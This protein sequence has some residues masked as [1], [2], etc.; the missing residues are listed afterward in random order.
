MKLCPGSC[1]YTQS[2]D[3]VCLW[4]FESGLGVVQSTDRFQRV[5][6]VTESDTWLCFY[7]GYS[8][9]KY[10]GTM[11]HAN[12]LGECSCVL[13]SSQHCRFH[14]HFV[15]TAAMRGPLVSHEPGQF[16]AKL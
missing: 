4:I 8:H 10:S 9:P 5:G 12:V 1:M 11:S 7:P 14:W 6:Q 16:I 2:E 15:F 13:I 3:R